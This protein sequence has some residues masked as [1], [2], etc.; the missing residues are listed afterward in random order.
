MAWVDVLASAVGWSPMT[1]R[2]CRGYWRL[3]LLS[4]G[5]VPFSLCAPHLRRLAPGVL[6]PVFLSG[7][8][9]AARVGVEGS[10]LF[11]RANAAAAGVRRTADPSLSL[12][13]TKK[14]DKVQSTDPRWRARSGCGVCRRVASPVGWSPM[15][16]LGSVPLFSVRS[17]PSSS[18]SFPSCL[19]ERRP[20]RSPGRS[21]RI[22]TFSAG[23]CR[24]CRCAANCRSFAIAQDDKKG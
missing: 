9:G 18:R 20:G 6:F 3:A 19:P 15:L 12:R 7:G 14:G 17:S 10:A 8:P 1:G 13:T 5:S 21:R 11:L 22:C 16:S 4:L 2:P 23:G 24:G